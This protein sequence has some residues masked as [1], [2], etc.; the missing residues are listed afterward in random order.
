[1]P[2]ITAAANGKARQCARDRTAGSDMLASK[3]V[4]GRVDGRE[5]P[6]VEMHGEFTGTDARGVVLGMAADLVRRE[7]RYGRRTLSMRPVDT[8]SPLADTLPA[9]LVASQLRVMA[10]HDRTQFAAAAGCQVGQVGELA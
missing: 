3:P 8:G 5:I 4:R 6:P 7:R 2:S 1:M 9:D 10:G